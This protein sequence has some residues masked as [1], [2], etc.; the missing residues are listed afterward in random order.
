MRDV[1]AGA[2]PAGVTLTRR[3]ADALADARRAFWWARSGRTAITR[4]AGAAH[5]WTFAGLHAN[6]ALTAALGDLAATSSLDNLRIALDPDRGGVPDVRERLTAYDQSASGLPP[7]VDELARDLKFSDC[8]PAD[9]ASRIVAARVLDGGAVG[10]VASLPV[11]SVE[12][13]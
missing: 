5:W 6:A 1:L 3:A 13:H 9:L 4:S 12:L 7:I 10:R 2:T 11:D 8:L